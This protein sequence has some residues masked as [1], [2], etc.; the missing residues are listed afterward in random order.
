M[1]PV[2][3][4]VN[5][6]GLLGRILGIGRSKDPKANTHEAA[7]LGRRLRTWLPWDTSPQREH[8]RL[9]L[10][11]ARSRDSYRN[12]AIARA[13]IDRMVADVIGTGVSPKPLAE[14]ESMRMQLG[15]PGPRC[16]TPKARLIST[17]CKRWLSIPCWRR[18]RS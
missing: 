17:A 7:G 1:K 16:A 5:K 11:R 4:S 15:N 9:G 14:A 10:L 2:Q 6:P 3:H 12:N 8:M 13:A 18:A